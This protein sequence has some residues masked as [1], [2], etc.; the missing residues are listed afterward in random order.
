MTDG[1]CGPRGT[2]CDGSTDMIPKPPFA[3]NLS[4]EEELVAFERLKPRLAE[5][6]SA[7]TAS[8]DRSYTSVVV[9]SMTLGRR[10]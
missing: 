5:I 6:W 9:P 10:L 8:D 1:R 4:L 2:R 7:L 3:C